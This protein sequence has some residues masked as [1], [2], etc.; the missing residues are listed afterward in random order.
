MKK[1]LVLSLAAV[2]ISF[3]LPAFAQQKDIV[4]PQLRQQ[5]AHAGQ[6][7]AF[8]FQSTTLGRDWP[9]K[10]Y[11]PDGYDKSNLR[12]PVLFLLHGLNQDESTWVS[13]GKI[14]EVADQEIAAGNIAPLLLV[15]PGSGNNWYVDTK[16]KIET[17]FVNDFIPEIERKFRI[18]PE[19]E[20][21][22]IGGDS[23]GGYGAFRFI[24][25]YP[26]RFSVA[27]L[28]APSIFVL[29]PPANSHARQGDVFGNP[30]DAANWKRENYPALLDPFFAKKSSDCP[31]LRCWG[32]RRVRNRVSN[33]SGLQSDARA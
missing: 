16:E 4:D 27:L 22:G 30:F 9:Y 23:M 12:Y 6:V 1:R 15:M 3:A 25:K 24:L 28:L 2:A 5:I 31:L 10:V 20:G 19:R 17:A 7:L 13:E 29:E 33:W 26:E 8:S 14:N 21:R 18:L 32:P 11:L